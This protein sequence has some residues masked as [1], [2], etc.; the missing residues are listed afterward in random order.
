M[1]PN[2]AIF[3]ARVIESF[4]NEGRKAIKQAL[5]TLHS[6][7][8][9]QAQIDFNKQRLMD[10]FDSDLEALPAKLVQL[11][12]MNRKLTQLAEL[13]ALIQTDNFD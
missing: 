8:L 4:D 3:D 6:S 12:Q 13:P 11:R 2:Y 5:R 10:E 1:T 9:I 7:G